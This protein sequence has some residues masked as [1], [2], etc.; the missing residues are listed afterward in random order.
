MR[1]LSGEQFFKIVTS[2]RF[3]KL[4]IRIENE[5]VRVFHYSS[6]TTTHKFKHKYFILL[7]KFGFIFSSFINR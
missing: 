3:R 2:K 6:I 1:T 5:R 4:S 7:G